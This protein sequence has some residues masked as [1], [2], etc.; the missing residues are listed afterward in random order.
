MYM[1]NLSSVPTVTGFICVH[2]TFTALYITR[3]QTVMYIL[4]CCT[5]QGV[6]EIRQRKHK[7]TKEALKNIRYTHT[8]IYVHVQY[9]KSSNTYVFTQFT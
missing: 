8:Y 6:Q 1:I 4:K 7:N 5:K 9:I 2:N 3:M